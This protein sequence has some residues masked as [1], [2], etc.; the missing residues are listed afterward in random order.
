MRSW[1]ALAN[2]SD[3]RQFLAQVTE[4]PVF[5]NA[6]QSSKEHEQPLVRIDGRP[7]ETVAGGHVANGKELMR[8]TQA[9]IL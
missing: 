2:K 1:K 7:F 8:K 4:A 6:S 5:V 9:A 3:K